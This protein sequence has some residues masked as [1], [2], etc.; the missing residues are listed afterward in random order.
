MVLDV[1]EMVMNDVMLSKLYKFP[2]T[3]F[4][5]ERMK[6]MNQIITPKINK[7]KNMTNGKGNQPKRSRIHLMKNKSKV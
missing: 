3:P 2:L 4:H 6:G 5:M 7:N 1:E